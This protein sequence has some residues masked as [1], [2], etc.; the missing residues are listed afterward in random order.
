DAAALDELTLSEKQAAEL[1]KAL[2]PP[3]AKPARGEARI[4]ASPFAALAGLAQPIPPARVAR[5][6][7]RKPRA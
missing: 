6:R 7:R 2:R 1:A 4:P 3:R 5:K